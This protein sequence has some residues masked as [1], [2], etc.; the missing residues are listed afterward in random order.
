MPP[1]DTRL[2]L[3]EFWKQG[4]KQAAEQWPWPLYKESM[5]AMCDRCAEALEDGL[6]P[7]CYCVRKNITTKA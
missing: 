3:T 5:P 2:D 7:V 1:S 4:V 6:V